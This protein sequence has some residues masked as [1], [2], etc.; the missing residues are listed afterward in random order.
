MTMNKTT[1][2]QREKTPGDLVLQE[3]WRAKDAL[4]AS[5]GHDLD[6]FCAG[7][8][9][10]EKHSGHPVVNLQSKRKKTA[11]EIAGTA[12]LSRKKT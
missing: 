10:R 5:Y 7:M 12:R 3:V 8:R 4:A 11:N 1:D 6:K 9:E 2:D